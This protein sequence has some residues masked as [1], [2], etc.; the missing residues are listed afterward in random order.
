MTKSELRAISKERT[1]SLSPSE[2]AETD[3]K[4]KEKLLS[5]PIKKEDKVF[6]YISFG[7]E[8]ET[9]P[10]AEALLCRGCEVSVPLCHGNG[11]MEAVRISSLSELQC[12]MYGIPEPSEEGERVD[13]SSLSLIVV[14]GVAF[15]EDGSRLGRGAGYYDR[16]IEKAEN[17][18]TIALCREI[19]LFATVPTEAH[20]RR[21]DMIITENRIIG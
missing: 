18:K 2:R 3:E 8:I 15:G 11:E 14:P 13:A 1:A 17:A 6:I 12:G 19:T 5:L 10:I 9:R 16:F 21:V 7:K 20:D 4:I